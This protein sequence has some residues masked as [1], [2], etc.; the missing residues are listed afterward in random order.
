MSNSYN[1][2][3]QPPRAWSRVQ[4]SCTYINPAD[5]YSSVFIPLTG[6]T[7]TPA[8]AELEQK[9]QYKGNILQYRANASNEPFKKKYSQICRGLGP[10]RKKSYA[11]QTG[12]YTNPNITGLTRINYNNLPFPN[13]I[14]GAPNNISGPYQYGLPNPFDCSSNSIQDGGS[15]ICGSFSNPCTGEIIKS[16]GKPQLCFSTSC[17]DVPG[18]AMFICWNPK[19]PVYFPRVNKINNNSGNKWP[20]GYKGFVSAI[21]PPAPVLSIDSSSNSVICTSV[22]LSWTINSSVC[23]PISSYNIY[24]DGALINT[25]PYPLTSTTVYNLSNK[26][27][28]FY[29]TSISYTVESSPSNTISVTITKSSFLAPV[30]SIVSQTNTT[31]TLS[32]TFTNNVCIPISSFNIYQNG[33]IVSNVLYPLTTTTINN[34]GYQNYSFYVTAVS[35]T[36]QSPSSNLVY[37]TPGPLYSATNYY[38]T[39][40]SPSYSGVVFQYSTSSQSITF[41]YSVNDVKLLLVGGGGGGG[42]YNSSHQVYGGGGGG[43]GIYYTNNFLTSIGT[44]S[45]TVGNGGNTTSGTTSGNSSV[46][47]GGSTILSVTGGGGGGGSYT[48]GTSNGGL[49][50]GAGGGGGGNYYTGGIGGAGYG[51][52]TLNAAG[53]SGLTSINIPTNP[54]TQL[55][56]SGGGGGSNSLAPDTGN[57]GTAGL[58]IGGTY[59]GNSNANGTSGINTFSNGGGFGGGGGGTPGFGDPT[60]TPGTGG[61]GVVIFWWANLSP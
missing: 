32:W 50:G 21:T 42:Q 45:I 43:G 54:L 56:L 9:M 34:L 10:N 31:I 2:L 44:Y 5:N 59:G 4:S 57:G 16:P 51:C 55:Y 39:F 19:M 60:I 14:V 37:F 38:T 35:N 29:V 36:T 30:L 27:Y 48:S 46:S 61:S 3:P 17:S 26:T 15:L 49:A 53:S 28:E 1:Y 20:Q 24:Q 12:T 52:D 6:Q 7:V 18:Q 40:N 8:Q 41:N 11:T 13:Q 33:S 23:V 58:G 47:F 25:V 22:D